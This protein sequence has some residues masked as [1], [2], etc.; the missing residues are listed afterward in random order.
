[1]IILPLII[2]TD[3]DVKSFGVKIANRNIH[4][5]SNLGVQK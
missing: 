2:I 5:V 1:M 3:K 4:I